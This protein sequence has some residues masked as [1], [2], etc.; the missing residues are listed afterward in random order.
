MFGERIFSIKVI[1][2]TAMILP[3][4]AMGIMGMSYD[5]SITNDEVETK[6]AVNDK[7]VIRKHDGGSYLCAEDAVY[8]TEIADYPLNVRMCDKNN[9][10]INCTINIEKDK[11]TCRFYLKA[12]KSISARISGTF[13]IYDSISDLAYRFYGERPD[14]III[15]NS[16]TMCYTYSISER[17]SSDKEISAARYD[18]YLEINIYSDEQGFDKKVDI[19]IRLESFLDD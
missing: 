1:F 11:G 10:A 19:R 15:D 13:A 5:E 7:V 12:D 2:M 8:L 4:D 6:T 9:N 18:G 16:N 17:L 3:F 14:F